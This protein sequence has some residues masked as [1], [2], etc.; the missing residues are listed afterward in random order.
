MICIQVYVKPHCPLC[1]PSRTLAG[2]IAREFEAICVEIIELDSMAPA[3]WP[4]AV[5]ATPTWMWNGQRYCLGTP[6]PDRL[7]RALTQSLSQSSSSPP[8][9]LP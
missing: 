5:F 4:D 8:K 2:A 9:G 1:E 7:R 6:D 3:Q